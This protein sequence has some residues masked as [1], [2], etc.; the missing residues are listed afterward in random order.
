[1]KLYHK[2]S[3][4]LRK[5]RDYKCMCVAQGKGKRD[6]KEQLWSVP[7]RI[8]AHQITLENCDEMLAN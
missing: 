7:N 4:E 8:R 3:A 2:T 5:I 6:R 1:M